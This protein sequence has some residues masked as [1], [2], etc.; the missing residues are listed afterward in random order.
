MESMFALRKQ[1]VAAKGDHKAGRDHQYDGGKRVQ[2]SCCSE[3]ERNEVV[4]DRPE[5]IASDDAPQS[6]PHIYQPNQPMQIISEQ[7]H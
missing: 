4:D 1:S 2:M 6:L 3:R 5:D 7:F